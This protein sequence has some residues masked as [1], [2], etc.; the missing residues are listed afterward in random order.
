MRKV[1]SVSALILTLTCSTYAGEM[2][3]GVTGTPPPPTT[4]TDSA[5]AT[6]GDIQN[7]LTSMATEVALTLLQNVL[8]LL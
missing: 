5:K 8:A 3:N 1:I 4:V 7:G 2:Q 6:D